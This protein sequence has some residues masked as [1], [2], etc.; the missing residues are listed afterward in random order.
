[1]DDR[2]LRRPESPV[3]CSAGSS[4]ESRM[5]KLSLP[6]AVMLLGPLVVAQELHIGVLS[7]FHPHLLVIGAP[8]GAGLVVHAG[9]QSFTLEN[10]S[11]ARSLEIR[12]A[13]GGGVEVRS[14][15]H[16]ATASAVSIRSRN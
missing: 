9:E 6:L 13:A 14:G 15:S 8:M 7:L 2:A 3:K 16:T 4:S 5:K 12:P 11:G 10:S 1:M